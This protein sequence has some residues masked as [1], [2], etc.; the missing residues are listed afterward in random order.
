[1]IN[2]KI[3]IFE[4]VFIVGALAFVLF[5]SMPR[6]NAPVSGHVVEGDFEL[7][8]NG[9]S[10]LISTS[11]LFEIFVKLK[12]NEEIELLQPGTYYWKVKRLFFESEVRNFSI[13]EKT[14]LRFSNKT[15]SGEMNEVQKDISGFV[16][17]IDE[18][19]TTFEIE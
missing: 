5:N 2:K 4:A 14:I 11:P 15:L 18:E 3:L 1:M 13:R 10:V 6:I 9:G 12:E 16:I 8:I 17:K 7:E 19:N